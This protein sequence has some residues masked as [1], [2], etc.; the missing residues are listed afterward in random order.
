MTQDLLSLESELNDEYVRRIRG[1]ADEDVW[2]VD[3]CR[4]SW[5]WSQLLGIRRLHLIPAN[6]LY[7]YAEREHTEAIG[8]DASQRLPPDLVRARR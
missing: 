6:L 8:R 4:V 7:E 5:D 2:A 3:A 1:A